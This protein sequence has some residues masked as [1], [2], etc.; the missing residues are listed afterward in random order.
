MIDTQKISDGKE[1]RN[2][3]DKLLS[4][5]LITEN[6]C[7]DI[8]NALDDFLFDLNRAQHKTAKITC[9]GIYNSGKSSV[10]NAL[11]DSDH[12]KVGDV[13][14][15]ATIDEF[16]YGGF[17]YVDTPGLNANNFDNET[18]QK[19]FKDAD[20]ILF[21]TN[22][23]NGGLSSAEADFLKQLAEILGGTENLEAQ[24]IFAMSNLHQISDVSVEMIIS[25][26][27]KLIEATLGFKPDKIFTYD[28][29]TYE[30]G[31]KNK[32]RTLIKRSNIGKLQ[33]KITAT[34][35]N[36]LKLS[37]KISKTR[38]S[39][40]EL[41]LEST[42]QK[43]IPSLEN[44]L[45][46]LY[47]IS[48]SRA[49]NA[50]SINMAIEECRNIINNAKQ[51]ITPPSTENIP[52]VWFH[53]PIISDPTIEEKTKLKVKQKIMER[54]HKAYDSRETV[55]REAAIQALKEIQAVAIYEKADRNFFFSN[56]NK[57]LNALL[58]CNEEL[59]KA[60][61]TLPV[62]LLKPIEYV[63]NSFSINDS[64]IIEELTDGTVN[65]DYPYSLDYYYSNYC[66]IHKNDFNGVFH[67]KYESWSCYSAIDNIEKDVKRQFY[68][69]FKVIWNRYVTKLGSFCEYIKAQL[70][71]R[72]DAIIK[73][74]ESI[75]SNTGSDIDSEM[76]LIND[77][78]ES[79]RKYLK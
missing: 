13:P 24:T 39:S 63:N 21:V 1:L 44:K 75:T 45:S 42:I 62:D 14:T 25:E 32:K 46:K 69:N 8:R 66:E 23:L 18:A 31:K 36:I 48:K 5:K 55:V 28:A 76:H 6:D 4:D 17:V 64:S 27:S 26:H 70:D 72:L 61:V 40:K 68:S 74:A 43:V 53:F 15:T 49:I 52:S 79:I 2:T 37:K 35:K 10:L 59:K 50:K 65:Y 3:I 12:F 29:A 16:E 58:S 51:T 19:A 20:V 60:N 38:I 56:E 54:L 33:K 67:I 30:T 9:A 57:A 77:H 34:A 22:M 7:N 78:L 73:E 47:E 41:V 11:T 71:S